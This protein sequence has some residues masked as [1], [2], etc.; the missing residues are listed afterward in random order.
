[1][2]FNGFIDARVL[3][4][5]QPLQEYMDPDG[6]DNVRYV[7]AT[8]GQRF[9]VEIRF[10]P[11]FKLQW[12]PY[13]HASLTFDDE[14]INW[15][16]NLPT[17]GMAHRKGV[18][19]KPE[20]LQLGCTAA[21][22]DTGT[23]KRTFFV[24]GALGLA[25]TEDCNPISLEQVNKL[26]RL[27]LEVYRAQEVPRELPFITEGRLPDAR[28]TVPEK[29]LKG[30]YI[31]NNVRYDAS[32]EVGCA[33][34]I[35]YHDYL[36]VNGPAG[37]IHEFEFRY[38]NREILQYLGCIPRSPSPEPNHALAL[39]RTE[40]MLKAQKEERRRQNLEILRLRERLE[41][42]ERGSSRESSTTI[43]GD[44]TIKRE[45]GTPIKTEQPQQATKRARDEDD[46]E[47]QELM[48]PPKRPAPTIELEDGDGQ[49]GT[50]P[51]GTK[52]ARD[53]D[54]DDLQEMAPPPKKM[55]VLVDLTDDD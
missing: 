25:E 55:P 38:R 5:G 53:E 29:L 14:E 34:A 30:R 21:K 17:K 19:T 47:L 8:T 2:P 23:W 48:P 43:I 42:A 27:K 3:V 54:D 20:S 50:A 45:D 51:R 37:K 32:D 12:A 28:E 18:L 33:P 9:T 26:G 31:K 36:P 24:F 49:S 46:D 22:D 6:I 1:M 10:L 35:R 11:G 13:L 44:D 4:D 41:R 16:R 39:E 7:Q 52:R 40:E 15:F